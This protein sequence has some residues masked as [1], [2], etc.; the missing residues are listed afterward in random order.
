[1]SEFIYIEYIMYSD[2]FRI[3]KF[4]AKIAELNEIINNRNKVF[5]NINFWSFDINRYISQNLC[6][7]VFYVNNS[8]DEN[9]YLCV[10]FRVLN[11]AKLLV[12]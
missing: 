3:K 8:F 1:M 5:Y 4:G 10:M 6:V 12:F 7:G 2:Y 11:F 9:L